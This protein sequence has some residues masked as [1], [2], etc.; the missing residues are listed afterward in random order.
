MGFES[1]SQRKERVHSTLASHVFSKCLEEPYISIRITVQP[2]WSKCRVGV[3]LIGRRKGDRDLLQVV[4]QDSIEY[5]LRYK[6]FSL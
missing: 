3:G 2:S 5:S 4:Q 6:C 1:P